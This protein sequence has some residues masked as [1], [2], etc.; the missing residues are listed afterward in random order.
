M[1]LA[2]LPERTPESYITDDE[3][4]GIFI[5]YYLNNKIIN[6]CSSQKNM[7]V[8]TSCKH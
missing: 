8:S 3:L 7:K 1:F 4:E 5:N 2:K 6:L